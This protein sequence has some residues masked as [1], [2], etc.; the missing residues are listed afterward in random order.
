MNLQEFESSYREAMAEA[1][2]ELQ[3]AV[4]MLAQVQRKIYEI[5]NSV[6][7]LSEN[8]EEFINTQRTE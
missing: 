3:T 6:Q 7:H 1:L 5:G 2:N 4:L 8:V